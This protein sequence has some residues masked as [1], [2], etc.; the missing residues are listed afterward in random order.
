MSMRDR[1]YHTTMDPKKTDGKH[2]EN[3]SKAMNKAREYIILLMTYFLYKLI[4]FVV[5]T[6]QKFTWA[7]TGVE[8]TR[9]DAK[10]G[11][12]FKQSAHVQHIFWRRKLITSTVSDPTDFITTHK[13]FKHP[14]Y[15]LKPT[16]SLYCITKE[17]AV[18]VEL[19][20]KV[21][22]YRLD[23]NNNVELFYAKQF[24]NA[25]SLITMPLACFH[26][27]AQDLGKPKIPIICISST[28]HCGATLLCRVLGQLP[29]MIVVNEPDAFTSLAFLNKSNVF[30]KGEYEQLLPSAMRLLCKPDDR[31]GIFLVKTRPCCTCQ[32]EDI[33]RY[34]PQMYQIFVYRNSLKTVSSSLNI[35]A[36]EPITMV[37]KYFIDNKILSTIFPCFRWT[38]YRY[39]CQVL[40]REND[41]TEAKAFSSVGIFTLAWA[42]NVSR[43]LDHV[44]SRVPLIPVLYEDMMKSPRKTCAVLFDILE[45]R[46]EYI[47]TA[48][49]GFRIT[50]NNT[51]QSSGTAMSDSRK[52]IPH[53]F[54]TE[55]D[56]ILKRYGLPKLGERFEIP[57]VLD[58]ETNK[59]NRMTRDRIF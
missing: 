1:N 16:V 26:K 21:N 9:K 53:E 11:L 36:K 14:N 35:F 39:F 45:L 49:E 43:C 58:F 59:F 52:S 6:F 50:T 54:R 33:Y 57:G 17:E 23:S 10:S 31:A 28:G 3:M 18:F 12:M 19:N 55:A 2:L 38:L 41:S 34:F 24:E 4:R 22:L 51:V 44:D 13:Y 47:A 40:A 32:M 15:V 8:R 46:P 5:L 7:V 30:G 25:H 42:A 48:M 37:G 29:G 56:A 20:E 27:I